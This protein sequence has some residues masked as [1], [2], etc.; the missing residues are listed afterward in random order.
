MGIKIT[1]LP[2]TTVNDADYIPVA[3]TTS[4][5]RKVL[6]QD[7]LNNAS[8][9]V[10]SALSLL[11]EN[12][13]QNKAVAAAVNSQAAAIA[14]ISEDVD[15]LKSAITD[16]MQMTYSVN[17]WNEANKT[18][19]YVSTNGNR[20]S[21]STS[22]QTLINPIPV[23]AGDVVRFYGGNFST[24]NARFVCAYDAN[25]DAVQA[26]GSS[27]DTRVYTVPQGI[28]S[29]IPSILASVTNVM[30]TINEEATEYEPYSA[31]YYIATIDFLPKSIIPSL[32]TVVNIK[33]TDTEAEIISKMVN[34]YNT[35]NCDVVFERAVYN[36]GSALATV[37]TDYNLSG[38]NEIPIGNGC[39]YFFNGATLNA[40]M[41]LSTLG[42]DFYCN[43]L[44]AQNRASDFELHDGILMATDTR[45]VVHDDAAAGD[46]TYKHLY[47]NM[48]LIYTT[49]LRTEAI[50]KCIGGGTGKN[51]VIEMEGCKFVT[52]G[53][54]SAVS[55]HGNATD[56]AGAEFMLTVMDCW[57]SNSLRA[58]ALSAS[59][60]ARLFYT[61]NSSGSNLQT[62][63]GWDVTEFLNEVR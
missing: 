24:V 4:G 54:D 43:L 32:R 29:I 56:Y 5:T 37:K 40:V 27:S 33:A 49:N 60:T 25:G 20:N 50:R 19:G 48:Q 61:G 41:D 26:S 36:F 59:Q 9:P 58:G 57:I 15:D 1:E 53:T 18:I 11:S 8:P 34:A 45:Y 17:M 7:V 39:R 3:N 62:Y 2:S 63:T 31:P 55:F 10:D 6:M 44:G 51:G 38:N 35:K 16:K 22:Y 47:H 42:V 30:V 28:A 52:D 12:P 46:G 21:T 13:V 14:N 23:N